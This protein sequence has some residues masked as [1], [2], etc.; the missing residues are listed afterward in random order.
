MPEGNGSAVLDPRAAR[1][2][3]QNAHGKR[4]LDLILSSPNPEQLVATL[5]AEELYFTL[6]EIGPDD[7]SELVAMAT[8]EQFR[9]FVDM[10]AWRAR[11][12]GPRTAEVLRWLRLAREGNAEPEKVRSQIES[13]D[14]ELLALALIRELRVHEL[15]EDVQPEPENPGMAFYTPDRRFLLEFIGSGEYASVRQLIE[16]L[17][18]ADPFQAGQLI[19]RT[20]WEVPSEL[21]ESAR[22]WRDGRLRDVGVPDYDEAIAFYARPAQRVAG[23]VPES[24][25]VQALVAPPRPLLDAALELLSG[26]ELERAEESA[27]YAANAALVANRVRLDDAEE[28]G[29]ELRDARATLSLGL[30]LIPPETRSAPPAPWRRSRSGRSS[31]PRWARRTGC[32]PAPASWPHGP[33]SRRRRVRRCW[34]SRWR[35][36]SRRCSASGPSS[37]S[38]GS[39]GRAPSRRARRWHGPRACWRKGKR[40][41]PCSRRWEFLRPSWAARRRKRA[42]GRRW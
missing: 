34:T 31:R 23:P 9:H 35:A 25:A 39:D 18:A 21:E 10:A 33:G 40:P 14:V 28:V 16:D 12:E 7:A 24:P 13:L 42:W 29:E 1:R 37:T 22:R 15:S 2:A 8:P 32:R 30:E 5:P 20:R 17:Y 3:L 36:R 27:V 41:S 4:K 6:L 26:E 38:P 11:S 19:E